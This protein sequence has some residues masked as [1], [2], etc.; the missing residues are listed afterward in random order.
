[1]KL[2]LKIRRKGGTHVDMSNADEE[3]TPYH[4]KP[5]DPTR[6]D[7]PHVA[8]V[9]DAAHLKRFLS[10]DVYVPFEAA[11]AK[12]LDKPTA[13]V[14][15]QPAAS[16]ASAANFT[17]SAVPTA[18]ERPSWTE[19]QAGIKAKTFTQEQLREFMA[20]EEDAATPR[21][22]YIAAIVKALS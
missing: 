21:P 6:E 14:V 8:D 22:G 12:P 5:V 7:S 18:S 9:T 2:E 10:I 1:M 19:L 15:S 16:A 17:A 20:A 3:T 13:D 4:F 11:A